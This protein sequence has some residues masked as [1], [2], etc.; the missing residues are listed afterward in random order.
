M[1]ALRTADSGNSPRLIETELPRPIPRAGEVLVRVYAAGVTPAELEWYPTSHTKNGD[2][3]SGAVPCHEF[4]GEIAEIG[5]GVAEF[6]I[7]EEIYGMN[8]WF[9]DGALAEYCVTQPQCI[10]AKPRNL[11]HAEAA[12]VPIGALTAW[13][14]LFER[15]KLQPGERLL[16]QGGAGAVGNFAVQL[17]HGCGAH[18]AATVSEQNLEFAKELGADQI[19]DYKAVA[20]ED[21]VRD[22]DVVFDTVGGDTLRRSWSVLTPTGRMVTIA[23]GNETADDERTKRAFFIVE[24]S[25]PK[26]VEVGKQLDA[27]ALRTVVDTIVPFAQAASVYLG[28]FQ[29]K[30]R[31]KV[32]VSL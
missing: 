29:K 14:G 26:L 18:V 19:I 24:P 23:A 1:K 32:V 5:E 21:Q 9:A 8:D 2:S 20:F 22:V 28:T 7:G 27:G 17:A 31:G 11:N 15:A 12:A 30:G 25:H 16:V 13:Q 10:A 6:S 3:R 4:S